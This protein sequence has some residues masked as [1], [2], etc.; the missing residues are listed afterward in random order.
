MPQV[1]QVP[2]VAGLPFF[3][4]ICSGPWISFLVL[5]FMQKA[6]TSHLHLGFLDSRNCSR[7]ER[8]RQP[9]AL[10]PLGAAGCAAPPDQYLE[11]RSSSFVIISRTA[12]FPSRFAA[13]PRLSAGPI[14]SGVVTLSE[15]APRPSA[16]FE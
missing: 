7:T 1:P 6:S 5:H 4:V 11:M 15:Y 9:T 12:G 16:T 3:I 8:V 2:R 13:K 14:P 10:T